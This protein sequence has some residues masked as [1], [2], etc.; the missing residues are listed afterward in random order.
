MTN[1]LLY[2]KV[3]MMTPMIRPMES[4]TIPTISPILSPPVSLVNPLSVVTFAAA[5]VVIV[6]V[7]MKH[8]EK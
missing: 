3:T 5:V 8:H 4:I 1:Y 6:V 7:A 2:K